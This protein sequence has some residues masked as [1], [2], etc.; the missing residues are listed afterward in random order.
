[1]RAI[2]PSFL[3]HVD[4]CE[5]IYTK[6][7]LRY[8]KIVGCLWLFVFVDFDRRALLALQRDPNPGD[9]LLDVDRLR[10]IVVDP[11]LEATHLVF[12]VLVRGEKQERDV[13]PIRRSS[14]TARETGSRRAPPRQT[15]C[16]R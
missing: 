13:G 12:D 1:M 8:T 2:N 4:A 15:G 11:E 14:S 10:Q 9:D 7:D 6:I 5:H 16:R 3:I